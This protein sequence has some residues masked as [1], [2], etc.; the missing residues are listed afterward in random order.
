MLDE[1][2][3]IPYSPRSIVVGAE[4][5]YPFMRE[6]IERV[7]RAPVFE[8]YGS[9]EVMLMGAECDRHTGL[10]LTTENLL[11]EVVDEHGR[12]TP[13]GEEGNIVVTDLTNTGM[14][15]IRYVNGDRAIAGWTECPCGRGLPLLRQVTG[16]QVDTIET[17]DGRQVSGVFFPHLFKEFSAIERF[18]VVQEALDRVQ[19]RLVLKPHWTDTDRQLLDSELRRILGPEVGVEILPV[20]DI[21]LTAAGKCR[22][23]IR[24][25]PA[26]NNPVGAADRS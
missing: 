8:T 7:F 22:A 25:V 13:A 6:L 16:R 19:V 14:P 26:A 4:K 10:H 15:F 5:L 11:V 3:I 20:A 2:G 9:R 12:P 17:P 21:P 24:A 23:V 18:Q 1:R